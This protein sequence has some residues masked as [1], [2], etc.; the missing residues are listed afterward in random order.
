[1]TGF[2]LP[3]KNRTITER[4]SEKHHQQQQQQIDSE[5][6]KREMPL[7][8][9][10]IERESKSRPGLKY[11]VNAHTNESR[12]EKPTKPATGAAAETTHKSSSGEVVRVRHLL[13]KHNQSRNPSSWREKTITR[14]KEEAIELL[15]G[16][17][18]QIL[19]REEELENAFVELA[20]QFSDCSSARHGGDLGTFGRGQMQKPFE[21]SSFSLHVGELSNVV[22]TD[23]GVHILLRIA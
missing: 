8:E 22:D 11:Y 3:P 9:G 21:Q 15:R 16:Y 1:M 19:S 10:W 14:S 20:T 17:R 23:S 18:N 6:K 13:V 5:K 12:W 4:V 7:P 2:P